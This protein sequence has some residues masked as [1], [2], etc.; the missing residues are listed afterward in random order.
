MSILTTLDDDL[1]LTT[2]SYINSARE[3]ARASEVCVVLRHLASTRQLW[4]ALCRHLDPVAALL[5]S[6]DISWKR[7]AFVLSR[8][9]REERIDVPQ[10]CDFSLL[11]QLEWAGGHSHAKLPF[12][13]IIRH[14]SSQEWP[15]DG[16]FVWKTESL[17]NLGTSLDWS[18]MQD[19]SHIAEE[20][21]ECTNCESPL[22][23]LSIRLWRESTR[24]LYRLDFDDYST[25]NAVRRPSDAPHEASTWGHLPMSSHPFNIHG[26]P[27][28]MWYLD[29]GI[30][31]DA[32][33]KLRLA[34][35]EGNVQTGVDVPRL[36]RCAVWHSVLE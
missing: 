13:E 16:E 24:S 25:F 27:D 2:L 14:D 33:I 34:D 22:R 1:L 23:L 17:R 20:H 9:A 6:N 4:L 12:G 11:V 28:F 18:A 21:L 8:G 30:G 31:S 32:W 19:I 10:I 35:F 36:L 5:T 7:M 15:A 3:L 29:M 26:D